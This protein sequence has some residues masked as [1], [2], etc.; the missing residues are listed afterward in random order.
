MNSNGNQVVIGEDVC[1]RNVPFR[2]SGV[3][4]RDGQELLTEY[5]VE[6][7]NISKNANYIIPDFICK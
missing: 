6:K 4:S 7:S 3:L 5:E 2:L 1:R